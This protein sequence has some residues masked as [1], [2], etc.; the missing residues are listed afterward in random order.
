LAR[1]WA[2]L[3]ILVLTASAALAAC[4]SSGSAGTTTD[5]IATTEGY[6][7]A[8]EG[9]KAD[10]GQ[11][12]LE[13]NISDGIPLTGATSASKY[14]AA[15]KGAKWEVA[16]VSYPDPGST[17]A[18]PTKKACLVTPPQG[19]QLCVVT[20]TVST[21]KPAYFHFAVETRYDPGWRILNVDEVDGKPDNLLPTGNEAHIS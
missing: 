2:L 6:M 19:G 3:T 9:G 10:G 21:A 5:P 16:E 4:G 18:K 12:F 8:I 7:K 11:E 17:T 15:N 1:R 20:V 13:T 14:M